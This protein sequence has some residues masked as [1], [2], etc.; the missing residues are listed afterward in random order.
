MI[1]ARRS[2][3][4]SSLAAGIDRQAEGGRRAATTRADPTLNHRRTDMA[5]TLPPL[6]YANDALEPHIDAQTMEIHHGKHHKAY[7]TN[8]Q[9]RAR[10]GAR[11][12]RASRST[13]CCARPHHGARG[14]PHRGP[15]QRRRALQPLAVLGDHGPERRAASPTGKLAEAINERVRRLR[16]VQGDSSPPRA[17]AAS[18][19][20]GPGSSKRRRQA[21]RSRA[22][23]TRTTRSWTGKSRRPRPRRV[24]ARLLPEVP[25][26]PAG[27]H[28]RV[29]ERGELEGGREAIRRGGK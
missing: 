14:D 19:P 8:L 20:A 23:R 17:P 18:A 7:V 2:C 11:A 3:P 29:V 27:L 1:V 6:P 25:E 12:R 15:Q 13:S 28:R 4:R 9:R 10:E 16:Q 24:G 22:R 5:H 26:P 21:R